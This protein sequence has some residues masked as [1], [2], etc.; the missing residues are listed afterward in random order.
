MEG[1]LRS[2]DATVPVPKDVEKGPMTPEAALAV[3]DRLW[4]GIQKYAEAGEGLGRPESRLGLAFY[5]TLQH[6]SARK[7]LLAAGKAEAELDAMP[8]AQVVMLDILVRYRNL[9]DEHFVWFNA[10]YPEAVQ[11]LRKTEERIQELRRSPPFDYLPIMVALLLPAVDKVYAAQVRTERRVA[12]LRTVEAVRLHVAKNDGRLP[13]KL[14]DV[15]VVPVPADPVTA[16]PFE[17]VVEGNRFTIN[18]PPPPG[19]KRE[20]GNHWKYVVTISK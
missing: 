3:L 6:P 5:I 12:S 13:A 10:P 4:D 16:Q 11:G 19:D 2:M 15:T 20:R 9:R 7:S 8:P 17:Y 18:V 1:E 14:T